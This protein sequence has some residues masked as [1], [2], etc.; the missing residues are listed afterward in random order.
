MELG[1]WNMD[2]IIVVSRFW[3]DVVNLERIENIQKDV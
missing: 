2:D 1:F 3:D